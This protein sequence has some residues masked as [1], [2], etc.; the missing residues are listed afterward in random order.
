M[1][2]HKAPE[3]NYEAVK[4]NGPSS[5]HRDLNGETNAE[6]YLR[7]AYFQYVLAIRAGSICNAGFRRSGLELNPYWPVR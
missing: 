4:S 5:M 7:S 2:E 1:V 6:D 3:D